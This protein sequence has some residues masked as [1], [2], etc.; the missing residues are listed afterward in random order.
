[1]MSVAGG[2]AFEGI[3]HRT[4]PL[5]VARQRGK[6]GDGA[7]QENIRRELRVQDHAEPHWIWVFVDTQ[8]RD[9]VSWG[10]YA[11]CGVS[12]SQATSCSLIA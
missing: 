11:P 4:R 10:C 7:F 1:M 8:G 9:R 3:E 5:V 2:K 6:A 12:F